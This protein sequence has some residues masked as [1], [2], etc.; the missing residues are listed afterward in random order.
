MN[1]PSKTTEVN[2]I[3]EERAV[4][5]SIIRDN[6]S[7]EQVEEYLDELAFLAETAGAVTRKNT[8]RN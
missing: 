6:Q 8:R 3:I 4:L 1:N 7:L 5:V 2:P